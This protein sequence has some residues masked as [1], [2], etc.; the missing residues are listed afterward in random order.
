MS[1][2]FLPAEQTVTT[3]E[4]PRRPAARAR[5]WRRFGPA[6]VRRWVEDRDRAIDDAH[7]AGEMRWRW[8]E[9]AAG[10]DLGQLVFTPS[11]ATVSVPVVTQVVLGDTVRL[12]V[13]LRPGQLA[14]DI[15]AARPRLASL[16]GVRRISV[17]PLAPGLVSVELW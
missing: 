11:G 5:L 13:R 17:T 12:T 8:R 3:L 16:L 14:C 4:A 1:V 15:A 6:A 10:A 9:A 2:E 7:R